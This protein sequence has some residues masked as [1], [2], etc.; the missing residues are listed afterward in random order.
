[1]DH[2]TQYVQRRTRCEE[3]RSKEERKRLVEHL[4]SFCSIS[5]RTGQ[6]KVSCVQ[7]NMQYHDSICA[8]EQ[9]E[10]GSSN[11]LDR[12]DLGAGLDGLPA[13]NLRFPRGLVQQLYDISVVDPT[14]DIRTL[15]EDVYHKSPRIISE[16][17]DST[18]AIIQNSHKVVTLS[19][20][21]QFSADLFWDRATFNGHDEVYWWA[22]NTK[23]APP[24]WEDRP[25][26]G[27]GDKFEGIHVKIDNDFSVHVFMTEHPTIPHLHTVPYLD[28][29][30]EQIKE[31]V[32][33]L[34][35]M[36]VTVREIPDPAM[37]E[38]RDALSE[39]RRRH[40]VSTGTST[41]AGSQE[42]SQ[43]TS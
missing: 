16:Y 31:L 21:W 14:I 33:N 4:I 8:L 35:G 24:N 6:T 2:L 13:F 36:G 1:M 25:D 22:Y 17:L 19:Q 11:D 29:T 7:R 34:K 23:D 41:S 28:A 40:R 15:C 10:E 3:T 30:A 39:M 43:M 26:L 37:Q 20:H 42:A 27:D 18:N 5:P 9:S 32:K 38:I 12:F